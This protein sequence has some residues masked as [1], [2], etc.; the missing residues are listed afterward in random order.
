M[1]RR[2]RQMRRP[3]VNE[4]GHGH[5]LTFSFFRR[6]AF[7]RAEAT[8]QWLTEEVNET[9][10]DHELRPDPVELGGSVLFFE[11]EAK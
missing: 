3:A 7:L 9:R 4:P 6:F 5:E 2:H 11:H 10:A 1:H 8:C